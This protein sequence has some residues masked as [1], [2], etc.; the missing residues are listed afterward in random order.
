MYISELPLIAMH[1]GPPLFSSYLFVLPNLLK[2][3]RMFSPSISRSN[4]LNPNLY[5]L[6]HSGFNPV[7]LQRGLN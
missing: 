4:N 1:W 5:G 2:L 6:P 7:G 3:V